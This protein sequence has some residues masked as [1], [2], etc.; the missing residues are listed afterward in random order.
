MELQET[1]TYSIEEILRVKKKVPAYQRDFVWQDDLIQYFLDNLR[2]S[3]INDQNNYFIGSMVFFK[4]KDRYE[5]VDGQQRITVI[6]LLISQLIQN[7]GV[8]LGSDFVAEESI[9]YIF[10]RTQDGKRRK[11]FNFLI[12]PDSEVQKVLDN[13]SEGISENEE[14]EKNKNLLK[15]YDSIVEF[16]DRLKKD[17]I[18]LIGFYNFILSNVKTTYF[19]SNSISEALIIYSRLNSG[20]KPLAHLEVIKGIIFSSVDQNDWNKYEKLWEKLWDLYSSK[21][22]IGGKREKKNLIEKESTF[23]AYFFLVYYPDNVNKKFNLSDAFMSD[24]RISEFL[25]SKEFQT[26][27][28]TDTEK[29]MNNLLKFA[30]DLKQIREGNW[31]EGETK[32]IITDIALVAQSQTQPLI[33]LMTS[34]KCLGEE[35]L[36]DLFKKVFKL[37]F[38]FTTSVTGTGTTSGEWRK[39]A[40]VARNLKGQN[41]AVQKLDEKLKDLI[42]VFFESEFKDF[43]SNIRISRKSRNDKARN[44][45]KLVEMIA[46]E[47]NGNEDEKY[48]ENYFMKK[49]DIDHLQPISSDKKNE[50]SEEDFLERIGNTALLSQ[51]DNRGLQKL[52]FESEKKKA[53]LQQSEFISNKYLVNDESKFN[54]KDKKAKKYFNHYSTFGESQIHLRTEEFWKLFENYFLN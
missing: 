36:N 41:D 37:V 8:D 26:L 49:Y 45:L 53:A 1:N 52:A 7:I 23:L 16:L 9:R 4:D 50:D 27:V 19:L 43:Y 13:I 25:L 14:N 3:F 33:F 5:I 21:I 38:I 28:S 18:D 47:I 34:I 40:S 32:K 51:A 11:I 48:F 20:G 22:Q 35:N 12:K 17:N 44:L 24:K 2:E 10:S 31:S 39:L 29:F 54:G 6:H 46:R 30:K 15:C 42:K